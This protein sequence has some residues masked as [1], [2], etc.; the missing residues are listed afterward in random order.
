[1]RETRRRGSKKTAT[2]TTTRRD[3]RRRGL[4]TAAV[5]SMWSKWRGN[6]A[7]RFLPTANAEHH[8]DSHLHRTGCDHPLRRVVHQ[9][10]VDHTGVGEHLGGVLAHTGEFRGLGWH[11]PTS[12]ASSASLVVRFCHWHEH[13]RCS[14]FLS[15]RITALSLP[16]SGSVSGPTEPEVLMTPAVARQSFSKWRWKTTATSAV[17]CFANIWTTARTPWQMALVLSRKCTSGKWKTWTRSPWATP[18]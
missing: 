12:L 11:G 15:T 13:W 17:T 3:V 18:F 1:M 9:Q 2:T 8:V 16:S 4:L 7:W 10:F 6:R 5:V 14:L